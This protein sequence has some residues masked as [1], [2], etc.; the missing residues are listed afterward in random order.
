[1][2]KV[3]FCTLVIYVNKKPRAWLIDGTRVKAARLAG[4][5]ACTEKRGNDRA[6]H[7]TFRRTCEDGSRR[8]A[9]GYSYPDKESAA[10]RSDLR[11]KKPEVLLCPETQ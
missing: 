9:A 10:G 3:D 6:E 1:M 11:A 8:K 2:K 5:P 7:Q 4:R